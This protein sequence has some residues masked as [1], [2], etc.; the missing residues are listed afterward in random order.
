MSYN[1]LNF[2]ANT[3]MIKKS[4]YENDIC[5]FIE[6]WLNTQEKYLFEELCNGDFH[7]VF[8]SDYDNTDGLKKGRPHGGLCWV[9]NKKCTLTAQVFFNQYV[10]KICIEYQ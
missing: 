4:I 8:H 7:I 3:A 1:C 5:F 6:H 10:S 2:K 9:I